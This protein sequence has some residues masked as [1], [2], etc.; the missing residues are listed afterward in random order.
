MPKKNVFRGDRDE[1]FL[2]KGGHLYMRDEH[3]LTQGLVA[4][5][6]IPEFVAWLSEEHGEYEAKRQQKEESDGRS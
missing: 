1:F 6:N 5:S 3:G 2:T 4:R